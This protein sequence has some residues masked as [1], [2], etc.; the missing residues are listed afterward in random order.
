MRILYASLLAAL[1]ATPAICEQA[2]VIRAQ[3]L[4]RLE[5]FAGSGLD[6]AKLGELADYIRENLDTTG[7]VVLYDGKV[8]FEYGDVSKISYIASCRKSVLSMLYGKH[9][10]NGTIDLSET[11]GSI[12]MDEDDGLLPI[13]KQATVDHL[14]T[15]RSGVFHIPAN[16]GYDEK[17]ILERG[18]VQPGSYFVYNNWDFN[19]AGHVLEAKTGNS[20]YQELEQQLAIPLGFEDWDIDK[21]K[22]KHDAKKSRYPAYHIFV[23]T[24]DMAKIGQLMLNRGQW[25]GKQLISEDW[26]QKTI[27]PVTPTKI[28]NERDGLDATS[29]FQTS[30]GYM[31]WILENIKGHPDFDG[32]YSA[33]G[34]GGQYITVIPKRKLV[35][36]HK[37]KL[38]LRVQLGWERGGVSRPQ[39][40]RLLHRLVSDQKQLTDL[41]PGRTD[42]GELVTTIKQQFDLGDEAQ[43]DVSK[44]AI[45]DLGRTLLMNDRKE[46]ALQIFQLN[47]SLYPDA[48]STH[49]NYGEC[50]ARLKRREDSITALQKSMRLNPGNVRV[51]GLLEK[52]I[53]NN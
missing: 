2:K 37:T 14:V 9:V 40:W 21:Q 8:A 34:F 42:I 35:V 23:S 18:S 27:T 43:F 20:V 28:V 19:A 52:L 10:E 44:S 5:E 17:N 15:S 50:L 24:R 7:M 16:G 46:D 22:K 36:A 13:E 30:Y 51:N 4:P 39:Y 41:L 3:S 47:T 53:G 29:D 12:G 33:T 49:A 32:A 26:I 11:I 38:S 48:Y 25:H 31:W 45:S 6:E 1:V